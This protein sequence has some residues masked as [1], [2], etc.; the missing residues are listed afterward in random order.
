MLVEIDA[1]VAP[2]SVLTVMGPSGSGKSTLLAFLCGVLDPAFTATGR[3]RLDGLDVTGLP[4]E[5][6]RI[7]ILFQDA[8]LF[9][10]LSVGSNLMVALPP[11]IRGRQERRR[12]VEAALARADLEGMG[13]RDPATL[14]GGQQARVAL[15]RTL[16]AEPAALLLDE[17]FAKLDAELRARI[18]R[19]VFGEIQERGLPALLVTHDPADAIAAGG[20]VHELAKPP[21]AD[22]PAD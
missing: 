22:R 6:R 13:D 18:R 4:P 3:V 17:P 21:V 19:F 5:R 12:L 1:A 2:G 14:S 7:G 20:Q 16:L 8:M 11:G 10:H 9:P 15:M